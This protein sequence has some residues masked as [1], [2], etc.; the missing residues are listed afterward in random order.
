MRVGLGIDA[1]TTCGL[2][3]VGTEGGREVM[4]DHWTADLSS[5]ACLTQKTVE[6]VF[7]R[8]A[9]HCLL[10]ELVVAIEM[11]YVGEN[12]RTA[13]LLGRFCGRFEQEAERRTGSKAHVLM[14]SSWQASVLGRFGGRRRDDK[15]KA[16]QLWARAMFGQGLT[17][18]EAD[19]AGLIVHVLRTTRFQARVAGQIAGQARRQI[20][21]K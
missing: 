6:G 14:A 16:A 12:V 21:G 3:L 13:L 7:T 10:T 20:A 1:A 2:A 15:K 11:P 9:K 18:D 17:E 8:A 5:L 4:L 19:A